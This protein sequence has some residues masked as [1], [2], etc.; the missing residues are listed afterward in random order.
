MV[1]WGAEGNMIQPEMVQDSYQKRETSVSKF[2]SMM[3][4]TFM[5]C[6]LSLWYGLIRDGFFIDHRL[7][8]VCQAEICMA[9]LLDQTHPS[10]FTFFLHVSD[11]IQSETQ[12]V[13][14]RSLMCLHQKRDCFN[15]CLRYSLSQ[16]C[17]TYFYISP[18]SDWT[19]LELFRLGH[20]LNYSPWPD[21][22]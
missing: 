19:H 4:T 9:R 18:V 22:C 13:G 12:V 2:G 1:S 10:S 21:P 7:C 3:R 6:Y 20:V 15:M 16:K 5:T 8:Y 17:L 14:P 11:S